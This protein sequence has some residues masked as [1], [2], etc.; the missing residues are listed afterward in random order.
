MYRLS[1]NVTVTAQDSQPYNHIEIHASLNR[2]ILNFGD[3]QI[4]NHIAGDVNKADPSKVQLQNVSI[5]KIKEELLKEW[6]EY[7][8]TLP[9]IS[10]PESR[11]KCVSIKVIR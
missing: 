11:F 2:R 10:I 5:P 1:I 9:Y 3:R 6:R 8:A 4:I 7:F